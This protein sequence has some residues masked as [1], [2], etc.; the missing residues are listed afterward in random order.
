[1]EMVIGLLAILKAGG[2]Y[3][4]LDPDYPKDRL[5]IMIENSGASIILT[6]R[7]IADFLPEFSGELVFLDQLQKELD[8]TTDNLDCITSGENLAYII[9]TSGS[10]GIPKGVGL[11]HRALVNLIEWQLQQ[12]HELR[13][14]RTLQFTSLSF[15]VSFQEIFSTWCNG[16]TL[17]LIE[18]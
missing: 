16:G 5:G 2:A 10:T 18:D 14:R 8:E 17:V 15:D 4:P 9:Y 6:Q 13:D 11:P 1:I 7:A 12:D 3:V